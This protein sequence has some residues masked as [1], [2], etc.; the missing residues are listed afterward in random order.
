M[1]EW[2]Y[3]VDYL[4]AGA[5]LVMMA[6]GIA[7]SAYMPALDKWNKRYFLTLFSLLFL[8][9]VT[10]L[11]SLIFYDDPTKAATE[12]VIYIV[13]S[14][15]ISVPIFMPT[16]FLLHCSHEKVKRSVLFYAM[17]ALLCVYFAFLIAAQFTDVFYYVTDDNRFFYGSL[18]KLSLVP[19]V[20]IM[21][22]N[23]VGVI[24]R[25][26]KL[27][28]KYLVALLVYLIPMTA[29]III[30]MFINVELF[31]V[32]GMALLAMIMFGLILSDNMDQY[33]RQQ[34]EIAHQRA[35]VMVLQ[36][37]P[38]FIYN[39][40]MTI[41]CL[42]KQDADKAQQ[43][44][45]DFT[46][47]LRNN[48]SA[49]ASENPVPFADELK[50]TQAYLA[51]EQAQHEDNLFTNFDTPHIL[52]RVPPLTLQPLVENAVK[53]GMKLE[54][55]PLHIYVKTRKTNSGSEIVV[56]NDGPGFNPADDNEPHIALNNIRQRLEMM[57]KGTLTISPRDGGGTVVTVS[58][59]I[60]K[61]S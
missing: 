9:A 28:N 20:L 22:L 4:L 21:L 57:C 33:M 29:A 15:F 35:N 11:L 36:M 47:Y 59:P 23:I 5:L 13:E 54:G 43:V 14:L 32:F 16:I 18:Y 52:F 37:R 44:T 6:I 30:H 61:I 17:T 38:H 48:F 24:I 19:L 60:S 34:Q 51:V 27:S 12:R 42:C 25:R 26:K 31:V 39:T 8:C 40:M 55:A 41:Y 46:D 49:I 1:T 58:I 3:T 45:L 53:H 56:E 10:C 7:F 50:H 2:M